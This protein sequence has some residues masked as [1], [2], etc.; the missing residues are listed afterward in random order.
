MF[1][2]TD[3]ILIIIKTSALLSSL[4]LDMTIISKFLGRSTGARHNERVLGFVGLFI[5]SSL[6]Y[7]VIL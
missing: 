6:V 1:I 2:L 3:L 5:I 4:A 7:M